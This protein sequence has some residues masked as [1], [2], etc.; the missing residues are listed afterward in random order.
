MARKPN[1]R[2]P[3]STRS[4]SAPPPQASS[5]TA[6]WVAAALLVG[7]IFGGVIGYF[8]GSTVSAGG[9]AAVTD[10]YGRSP[11]HPHYNHNHP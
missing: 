11:S 2:K 9:A 3:Q 4:G 5:S 10:A 1:K 7:L 8:V 6:Q